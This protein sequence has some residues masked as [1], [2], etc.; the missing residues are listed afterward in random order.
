LKNDL[1]TYG[2]ELESYGIT[3]TFVSDLIAKI[4][5]LSELIESSRIALLRR[6]GAT[7]S[8][9]EVESKLTEI[10]RDQIDR[11]VLVFKNNHPQFVSDYQDARSW[12]NHRNGERDGG[13]IT[14]A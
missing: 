11:M 13:S 10:L 2:S 1:V 8:I 3:Q 14:A 4:D 6:K 9:D 5:G 7:K 12:I